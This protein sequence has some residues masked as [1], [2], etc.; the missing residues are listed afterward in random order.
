MGNLLRLAYS[1]N[2]TLQF[3]PNRRLQ[4]EENFPY[5]RSSTKSLSAIVPAPAA[6]L[7]SQPAIEPLT[8]MCLIRQHHKKCGC[9]FGWPTYE[10]CDLADV[11][12]E[13]LRNTKFQFDS[14]CPHLECKKNPENYKNYFSN[15]VCKACKE[16]SQNPIVEK[17]DLGWDLK[18]IGWVP[19]NENREPVV[20]V[21]VVEEQDTVGMIADR[22]LVGEIVA[23]G[24]LEKEG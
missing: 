21:Y 17:K 20:G 1:T 4:H 3:P 18:D 8:A 22:S 16:K 15:T 9:K 12:L 6:T 2:S 10:I 5:S 19:K 7:P 23:P 11:A 14:S 13:N 24:I